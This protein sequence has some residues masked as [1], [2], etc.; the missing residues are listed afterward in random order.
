MGELTEVFP[1][2]T[3]TLIGIALG[4]VRP[5]IR[6]L[7]GS[8]LAVVGGL[9]AT[10]VSGEFRLT[11]AYLLIDIPLVASASILALAVTRHVRRQRV[12]GR[13]EPRRP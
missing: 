10:V 7:V 1:V 9:L 2:L 5:G 11:W 4:W 3:G 13:P 12:A 6:L 8:A